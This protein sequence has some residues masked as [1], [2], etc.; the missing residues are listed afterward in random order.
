MN[1]MT[2]TAVD[3]H[4]LTATRENTLD[5]IKDALMQVINDY[6]EGARQKIIESI[7]VDI[8]SMCWCL[9]YRYIEYLLYYMKDFQDCYNDI[10]NAKTEEELNETLANYSV[11][12]VNVVISDFK[13]EDYE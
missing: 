9:N 11:R 2:K 6:Y 5:E 10:G 13:E 7:N 12:G 4:G 1:Y 3:V 8:A